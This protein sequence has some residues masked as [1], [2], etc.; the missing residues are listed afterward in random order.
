M[1]SR[2]VP[3]C[4]A[5]MK[6]VPMYEDEVGL[7]RPEDHMVKRTFFTEDCQPEKIEY[8]EPCPGSHRMAYIDF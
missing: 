5:C 4:N 7:I 6:R 1:G 8:E 2:Y 3:L